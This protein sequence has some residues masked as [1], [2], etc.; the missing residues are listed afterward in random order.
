MVIFN[1]KA[2]DTFE[3]LL[4]II[5]SNSE[6]DFEPDHKQIRQPNSLCEIF[7]SNIASSY[8]SEALCSS[9]NL[10]ELQETSKKTRKKNGKEKKEKDKEPVKLEGKKGTEH[11][12]KGKKPEEQKPMHH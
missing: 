6:S 10:P 2:P 12:S 3:N 1:S 4:S 5:I 7:L 9:S 11:D 8:S